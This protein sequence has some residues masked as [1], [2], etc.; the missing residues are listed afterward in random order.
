MP[1]VAASSPAALA[2]VRAAGSTSQ[3]GHGSTAGDGLGLMSTRQ[4]CFA[5][6]T[7]SVTAPA[8]IRGPAKKSRDLFLNCEA[9]M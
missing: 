7:S 2:L 3:K 5:L 1:P 8:P 4:N 9:R 6:Y